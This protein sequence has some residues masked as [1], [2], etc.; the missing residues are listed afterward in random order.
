[1]AKKSATAKFREEKD[2]LGP[3]QVPADA[4]YGINVARALEN[5]PISRRK[6]H[7]RLVVAYCRIKK[8]AAKVNQQAGRLPKKH[9]DAIRKAADE[10][11]AGGLRDHFVVDVFQAG[12]G[13]STN[14]NANEVLANR[15]LELIG[16]KKGQYDTI[17]PNDHVNMGQSTNDTFP[18]AMRLSIVDSLDDFKPEVLALAKS[19]DKLAKKYAKTIKSGRTHLQDAVPV[20]LGSEFAAYAAALRSSLAHIERTAT[21]LL[22]LGIGGSAA[23]TGMTTHPAYAKQMCAELSKETKKKFVKAADLQHAMQSQAPVGR[24]S[25]AIRDFAV[26]LGRIA[27]DLR[28]LSSGPTT[29]LAEIVLP[30]VQAGSSIMPGKINPSI[31]EMVNMTCYHVIGNDEC[32][33]RSVGAGQLELN[34]MMPIMVENVL[35][36]LEVLTSTCRQLRVRCVDG[37]TVNKDRCKDYAY[38]SMGLATALNPHIGYLNAAKVAKAALAEGKTIPEL[39]RAEGMLSEAELKKV[40]D[41]VAM[42]GPDPELAKKA[43]KKTPARKKR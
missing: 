40:L 27:N 21:D 16:K 12:A 18:T 37:I 23:G 9:A 8:A 2:S 13:T 34:V 26:E 3:Y 32:V 5:F 22:E 14:M 4:Y 7:P 29:G 38:R 39:V 6:I 15:A 24:T 28:L 30:S 11:I 33:S 35:E 19:F 25:G 43:G 10:V 1:M 36:S 41:P 31:P 20:T 42:T 17:S